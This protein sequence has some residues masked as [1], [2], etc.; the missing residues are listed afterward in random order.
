M[1]DSR[2]L[3]AAITIGEETLAA[4]EQNFWLQFVMHTNG[5]QS[6]FT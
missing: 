1:N 3:M 2:M 6:V 5:T 4:T